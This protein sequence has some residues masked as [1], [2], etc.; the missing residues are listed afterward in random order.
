MNYLE[1]IVLTVSFLAII[2][3]LFTIWLAMMFY[4]LYSQLTLL[5]TEMNKGLE[6]STLRLERLPKILYNEQNIVVPTSS[7]RDKQSGKENKRQEEK[8][9]SDAVNY[10][11]PQN[12][13]NKSKMQDKA[14]SSHI[15]S[16]GEEI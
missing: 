1:V 6:M 8:Q 2:I 3:S 14:F 9:H 15:F 10:S 4:R 13:E 12:N 7:V 5:I 16:E 11:Q